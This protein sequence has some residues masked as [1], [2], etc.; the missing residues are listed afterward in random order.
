ML[1]LSSDS[2][3]L[4][5]TYKNK[6]SIKISACKTEEIIGVVYGAFSCTFNQYKDDIFKAME[7]KN[8]YI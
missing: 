7:A 4:I 2:N 6:N 1:S 3:E 8:N 5:W